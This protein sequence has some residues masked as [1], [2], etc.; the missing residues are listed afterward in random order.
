MAEVIND[1]QQEFWRPVAVPQANEE[2]VLP[3]TVPP[4]LE[5]ACPRCG[6]EFM[7]GARF[8]HACGA[9][10][11]EISTATGHGRSWR[12]AVAEK[13]VWLRS[14]GLDMVKQTRKI[15]GWLRYLHFHEIK[16][17]IGL[18][19][20]SLVAFLLGVGCAV[21]AVVVTLVYTGQ[22]RTFNDWQAIQY[23]RGECLL[24]ATT[25]FVAGILLKKPSD[26]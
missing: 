25:C 10:R 17:W 23:Y 13:L 5:Q 15:P 21:A 19:T 12:P 22:A 4:A 14:A 1:T 6:S 3:A 8:C 11:V 18:P 16:R 26:Q 9:R 20:A 2:A 24:A 7:I